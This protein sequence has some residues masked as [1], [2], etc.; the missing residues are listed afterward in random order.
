MGRVN[1]AVVGCSNSTR[2]IEKWSK[3][4][5]E[6]HPDLLHKDCEC[7]PPFIL[8]CFPG[9]IRYKEKREQWIRLLRR[10]TVDKKPWKPSGSD[11]VCSVHFVDK[12]P[13]VNNPDPTLHLGYEKKKEKPPR[14][15]FF[16][17]ASHS[18]A[19]SDTISATSAVPNIGEMSNVF[20][21]PPTSPPSKFSKLQKD[22]VITPL[23][24]DH[25]YCSKTRLKKCENCIYK[26]HLI[27]ALSLKIK[28]LN[29]QNKK[30]R[31]VKLFEKG[32]NRTAF[33]IKDIKK[34]SKM[35]FYTGITTV[36]GF[37]AI[38]NLLEP[39]LEDI[40]YWKGPLKAKKQYKSKSRKISE[41]KMPLKDEFLL[42]LM[43]LRLGLLT[44]DLADRFMISNT[45]CSN[46]FKTWISFLS[47]TMGI[48]LVKWLPKENIL[49]HM[50]EAFKENG[51]SKLRC[52][53]DCSEIFIERSK[54]LNVQ[55]VTWSEYKHHNTVKFLIGIAPN[56]FVTFL[57][58]C[59]GGRASDKFV[60]KDSGFYD[61]L[62][63][64]DEI[65]ADRGFQITE[66]LL[67]RHCHLVVPPGA[68][69]KSQM[70]AM[71]CSKTKTV[72]NL[73][74]HVERAI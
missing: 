70:T 16:R 38:F 8:F 55:A 59:Y 54:S 24:T 44:E 40:V 12:M 63:Y 30:L 51:Y 4:A 65:M 43:K 61:Q 29:A 46:I 53:I 48:A 71:E 32:P 60:C 33:S 64:G 57:S 35:N 74:I 56:G 6:K 68:R 36:K 22:D 7:E 45:H 13:T 25:S 5:C 14:R 31:K 69:L 3:T 37:H 19:P 15:T 41:R 20:L 47:R 66:E 9:A 72:A 73:R 34:D 62:D 11:R 42:T 27:E 39:Y 17:N 49:K 23:I 21:S 58:D 1:C 67:L 26:G 18:S 2:T 52:I 28:Q 50:P 10:E